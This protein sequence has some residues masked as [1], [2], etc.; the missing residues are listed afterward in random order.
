M[1]KEWT[2]ELYFEQKNWLALTRRH[3]LVNTVLTVTPTYEYYK[4]DYKDVASQV[5]KF[6]PESS[7]TNYPFFAKVY[8]HLH[9][10]TD[11]VTGK[12]YRFPIPK[13]LTGNDLGITPQN[14]GY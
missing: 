8:K 11:N 1:E 2:L 7:T 5:A 14:P 6:G 10:K 9:S 3:K 13:G 4:E 12:F